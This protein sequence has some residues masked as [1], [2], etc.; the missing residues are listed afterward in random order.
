MKLSVG[1]LAVVTFFFASEVKSSIL[2]SG[3][4]DDAKCITSRNLADAS[5]PSGLW[6]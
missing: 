6:K 1:D 5:L 2:T 4:G 3:L